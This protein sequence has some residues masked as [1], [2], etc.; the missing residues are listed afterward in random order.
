MNNEPSDNWEVW[1]LDDNDLIF[2]V[3][4]RVFHGS[5]V[6][7]VINFF[8]MSHYVCKGSCHGS[9]EEMGVC[10]T[11]GCTN[12]WEMM[13]ECDCSDGKHGI[14]AVRDDVKDINGAV[15]QDGDSVQVTQDLKIGGG[16]GKVKRG[17]KFDNIKLIHGED[18]AV[19]CKVGKST[20]VIKTCYLR[21]A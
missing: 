7:L 12:Q 8:N 20:L 18:A 15:L 11:D 3:F 6:P 10:E 4:E 19:E 21:K 1:F 14:E 17:D 16:T 2:F 5:I 9:L 13:E